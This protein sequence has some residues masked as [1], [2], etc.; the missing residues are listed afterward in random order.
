[1]L[2]LLTAR[3]L[4]QTL[5]LTIL[6]LLIA[7][8][9]A[10]LACGPV[11]QLVPADDGALPAA[12]DGS[13]DDPPPDPTEPAIT[14]TPTPHQ[15]PVRTDSRFHGSLDTPL[16]PPTKK[17]LKLGPNLHH[18]VIEFEESQKATVE[19]S[20][21]EAEVTE[22]PTVLVEIALTHNAVEI[23]AWLKGKGVSTI[24]PHDRPITADDRHIAAEVPLNLIGDLSQQE[25]I[26]KIRLPEPLAPAMLPAPP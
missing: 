12:Q 18:N 8:A 15:T 21:Q 13:N 11:T 4:T 9:T 5:L 26:L 6:F 24:Y 25:G 23:T 19:S 20:E 3:N 16:P 22:N 10:L 14:D 17:Y 1:M 7:V 2:A